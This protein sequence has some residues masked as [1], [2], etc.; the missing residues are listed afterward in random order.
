MEQQAPKKGAYAKRQTN[1]I[2]WEKY[3][4][5]SNSL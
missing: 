3:K 1:E 4:D 2:I 5:D